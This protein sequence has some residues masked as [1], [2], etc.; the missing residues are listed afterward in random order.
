MAKR[1]TS[2]LQKKVPPSTG[3][4]FGPA[5]K[6]AAFSGGLGLIGEGITD[7]TQFA[8][9]IGLSKDIRF[10]GEQEKIKGAAEAAAMIESFNDIQA[11]NIVAAFAS[12]IRLQGSAATVQQVVASKANFAIAISQSNAKIKS[13]ALIREAD[14]RVA[15]AKFK[16]KMAPFKIFT[17]AALTAVGFS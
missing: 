16:K 5:V 10:K 4:G 9:R 15:E 11:A 13:L 8:G 1:K 12:G 7:I 14:R 17:G 2:L 3:S 6:G